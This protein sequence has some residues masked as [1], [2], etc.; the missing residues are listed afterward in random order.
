MTLRKFLRALL[1]A[2]QNSDI[3][4]VGLMLFAVLVPAA[5]LLWFM[6][7][8]MR[9][10]RFAARQRLAEAYHGQL[11]SSQT[12]LAR[13]WA[14]IAADLEKRA[15]TGPAPAAF[16]QCIQSGMVESVVI[17]DASGRVLYP[18][19]PASLE[20]V[21]GELE[22]TWAEANELEYLSKDFV[23][24]AGQY[25]ALAREATN[26]NVAARAL[27]GQARCLMRA[28]RIEDATQL[29]NEMLGNQR[30]DRVGDPQG[31]LISANAELMVLEVLTNRT[32]SVFKSAARRLENRLMDY[33]NP[34]LAAPQRRFL[35][36]ELRRLAPEIEF[37]TL[38]AEELAAEFL[39][40]RSSD[41]NRES[42][43]RRASRSG[44]WQFTTA[45][46]RVLALIRTEKLLANL[47]GVLATDHPSAPAAITLLPPDADS[48]AALVTLP[49]G[50]QLP[51]WRVALSLNNQA[52]LNSTMANRSNIYLWTGILVMTVMGILTFLAIRLLRRQAALARLKNDLAATVSHELKTPLSSMRVLVDTLLESDRIDEARAREYL[53]LIAQENERLS[54]LIQNFLSFSRMERN[55]HTFNFVALPA[56]RII[57]DA[58]RAVR[59]RFS[60]P[61]CHFEVQAEGELPSV[62]ADPDAL[63][64]ALINLLDNAWK[65]SGEIKHVVLGASVEGG[66][67]VFSVRDNGVGIGARERER[68]F[69]PFH[70]VDQRL[71]H[72]GSGCGLG[73]SIVRFIVGA[74]HG[75]ITVESE[76]GCGSTFTVSIPV[77]PVVASNWKEAIA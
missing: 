51:G 27:Q 17:F 21:S 20:N 24:A 18:A 34:A 4:P 36:K 19:A 3:W 41:E 5:C 74:H 47:E 16:A 29:V 46:H 49:A 23:A 35:M 12:R 71:S 11:L 8:A 22:R 52:F 72:K 69:S 25:G 30:Y 39:L 53:Q 10:E 55:K 43:L 64:T 31:R 44:V 14:D 73:L 26:A 2:G 58:V 9:N 42:A 33:E 56:R 57:D 68:I 70:Q 61:G 7:A 67:V 13:R 1:R 76:P 50:P 38:A 15:Q 6:S 32:S 54:R 45:N 37:P 63:S 48:A 62:M 65:Y 28:G 66:N 77:M 75:S 59:E 60:T 40:S